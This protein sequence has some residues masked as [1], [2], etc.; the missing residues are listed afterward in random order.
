MEC[1]ICYEKF[2]TPKTKEELKC[3]LYEK[4]SYKEIEMFKNLLITNKQ[5]ETHA[6]ST[7]N[8][9]CIICRDCWIKLTHKGKDIDEMTVDDMPT[10]NNKFVCPCCKIIDWKY[11]MN[12]VF[13]E[14]QEKALG[15]EVF[16]ELL[17]S[18]C[19]ND[20]D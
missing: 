9:K 8:C 11:Y 4:S 12:N 17:F 3:L 5:N 20:F 18:K 10:I 7:P 19:F 16:H 2:F 15:E 6:C 13:N 14:L 1:A